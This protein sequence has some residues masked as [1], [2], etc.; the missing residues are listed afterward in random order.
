MLNFSCND[1][2]RQLYRG[3]RAEC[4]VASDNIYFNSFT[5]ASVSLA[6]AHRYAGPDGCTFHIITVHGAPLM[7][8][9]IAPGEEEVLLT[10][11]TL[12]TVDRKQTNTT[13][14][15][16][17]ASKP[18]PPISSDFVSLFYG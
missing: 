13:A 10:P 16:V 12:Y 17:N 3:I 9:S 7:K 15:F 1:L 4:S 2:A 5:S 6:Q 8:F 11:E 18:W 14:I